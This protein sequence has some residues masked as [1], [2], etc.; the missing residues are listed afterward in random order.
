[1]SDLLSTTR[2]NTEGEML[3]CV[4]FQSSYYD[5]DPRMPGTVPIDNRFFVLAKTRDEALTKAEVDIAKVRGR[6]DRGASEKIEA[7]IV[8][9]EDLLPA[10]DRSNDGRMGFV[11][12]SRLE[13]V[14]LSHQDDTSRY[15][16][17]VCLIPLK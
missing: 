4:H 13:V 3:W 1:M 9:I 12:P 11:P 10:R 7:T 5:S 6:T 16:L 8:T 14:S 15:R 17:G 2:P